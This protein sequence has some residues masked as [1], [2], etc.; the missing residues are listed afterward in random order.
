MNKQIFTSIFYLTLVCGLA[1]GSIVWAEPVVA[2]PL[3]NEVFANPAAERDVGEWVQ[4]FHESEVAVVYDAWTFN[5]Q[6]LASVE[7]GPFEYLILTKDEAAFKALNPEYQGKIL[8]VP[9][10][11]LSNSGKLL[12]LEVAG[13]KDETTYPAINTDEGWQRSGP[14]CSSWQKSASVDAG[15]F[16]SRA[17]ISCFPRSESIEIEFS[18]DR[19]E[20]SRGITTGL[21]MDLYAQAAVSLSQQRWLD[22]KGEVLQLPFRSDEIYAGH[23][24]LDGIGTDSKRH[25]YRS[26]IFRFLPTIKINEVLADTSGDDQDHEWVELFNPA[27]TALAGEKF[28]LER[29]GLD[30][31]IR[32]MTESAD[33]KYRVLHLGG[34]ALENCVQPSACNN[35]IILKYEGIELDQLSIAD[36]VT[37]LS[38]A[39]LPQVGWEI[40]GLPTPG[41]A[42]SKYLKRTDILLTEVFATPGSGTGEWVEIYNAGEDLTLTNW[43]LRDESA[44]QI[45][46]LSLKNGEHKVINITDLTLNN[47]GDVLELVDSVGS[48]IGKVAYPTLKTSESFAREYMQGSYTQNWRVTPPTPGKQ[49]VQAASGVK[50]VQSKTSTTS[51]GNAYSP[52]VAVKLNKP[53]VGIQRSNI[54]PEVE[55]ITETAEVGM[56]VAEVTAKAVTASS[57][58]GLCLYYGRMRLWALLQQF[59]GWWSA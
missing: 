15:G 32:E 37:G 45:L 22:H 57:F 8:T 9:T 27:G 40:S 55:P 23:I 28:T 18:A 5:G 54:N 38:Y 48:I 24:Y 41:S 16:N 44:K 34:A 10:L 19:Q 26:D 6:A 53:L 36:T 12:S 47:S 42:N 13:V 43:S 59:W 33:R 14:A 11:S 4:V 29:G 56:N 49:N 46:D 52:I 30:V 51:A 50:E 20:W 7:L 58:A 35:N 39:Y 17:D 21:N 2:Q 31:E 25:T 1:A 3:L